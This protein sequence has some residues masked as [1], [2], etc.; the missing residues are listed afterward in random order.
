VSLFDA[1]LN[2]FWARTVPDAW[3]SGSVIN[4]R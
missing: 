4:G 3:V 1:K 2:L